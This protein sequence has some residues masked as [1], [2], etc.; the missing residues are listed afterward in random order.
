MPRIFPASVWVIPRFLMMRYICSVK[1]AFI[2]SWSALGRPRSAKTLP[3]PSVTLALL[4]VF[5]LVF[6]FVLPFFV[7][8]FRGCQPLVNQA[9][10][11]LRG[12]DARLGFLLE[13]MQDVNKPSKA[14]GIHRAPSIAVEWRD[15]LHD[16]DATETLQRLGRRVCVALLRHIECVS[17]LGFDLRRE[18]FEIFQR[19][20]DP[21]DRVQL[22]T[23]HY[24]IIRISVYL[25]RP[26]AASFA[27]LDPEIGVRCKPRTAVRAFEFTSRSRL[28]TPGWKHAQARRRGGRMSLF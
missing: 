22:L 5:L 27:L 16:A 2:S 20:T 19:R 8:S 1:R 14:D 24:T 26:W 28:R 21:S 15:D 12:D 13:S 9:D 6:M 23:V 17:D 10:V 11:L 3:L 18:G 4:V 25:S 7:V